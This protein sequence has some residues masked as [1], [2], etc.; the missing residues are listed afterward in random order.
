MVN[1]FRSVSWRQFI[2]LIVWLVLIP[3]RDT[4]ICVK[5]IESLL[6]QS[7]RISIVR[8]VF[9][10]AHWDPFCDIPLET[11]RLPIYMVVSQCVFKIVWQNPE[12][13]FFEVSSINNVIILRPVKRFISSFIN[14]DR[15]LRISGTI[16]SSGC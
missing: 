10:A 15:C 3:S 13:V 1:G 7:Y 12:L 5:V 14:L 9:G 11:L 4:W 8:R 16:K 6:V 2:K